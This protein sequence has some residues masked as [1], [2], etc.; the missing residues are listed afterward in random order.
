MPGFVGRRTS[1]WTDVIVPTCEGSGDYWAEVAQPSVQDND[2]AKPSSLQSHSE[3]PLSEPQPICS[4]AGAVCTA[5]L[6]SALRSD[7]AVM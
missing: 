2:L 3:F 7:S 1:P 6:G 4:W 5:W